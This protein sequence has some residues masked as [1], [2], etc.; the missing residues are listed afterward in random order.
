GLVGQGVILSVP[1]PLGDRRLFDWPAIQEL[2]TG[3]GTVHHSLSEILV[4]PQDVQLS[5]EGLAATVASALF[6]GER[7]ALRLVLGDGQMLRAFSRQP[8]KIG[9]TLSVVI[10]S[11]WRL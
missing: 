2:L 8:V 1:S 4:R 11:A 3:K 10:Q 6:E 7:Y 9:D 5:G